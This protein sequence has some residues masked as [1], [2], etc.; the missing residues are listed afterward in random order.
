M[1]QGPAAWIAPKQ[2][3]E[4]DGAGFGLLLRTYGAAST[5]KVNVQGCPGTEAALLG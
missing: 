4:N 5:F 2:T 3:G 1:R